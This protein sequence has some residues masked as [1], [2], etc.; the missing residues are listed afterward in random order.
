MVTITVR[1]SQQKCV[2]KYIASHYD[3]INLTVPQGKK[4][5]I[6]GAA[7]ESGESVNAYINRAI[8]CLMY[9][10]GGYGFTDT[11]KTENNISRPISHAE[12]FSPA[13]LQQ[14]AALLK[15]GQTVEDFIHFA[16]LD[17]L[18]KERREL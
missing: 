9:G 6:Q 8:D 5:L 15:D 17:K 18:Q 2:N 16:V 1:K 3:R 7:Q 12:I 14:I 11:A 10:G 4:E 13:E